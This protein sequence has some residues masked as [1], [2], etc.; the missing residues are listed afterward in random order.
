MKT[1]TYTYNI[2]GHKM[3]VDIDTELLKLLPSL[4]DTMAKFLG[5]EYL[6]ARITYEEKNETI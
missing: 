1:R 5:R 2:N 6:S 4:P 3:S